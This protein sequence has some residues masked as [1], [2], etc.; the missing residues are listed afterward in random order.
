VTLAV[1]GLDILCHEGE[2]FAA[3]LAEAGVAV[4]LRRYEDMIH[5]FLSVAEAAP[6]AA[7]AIAEISTD[8]AESLAGATKEPQ[9][10]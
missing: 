6:T 3:R 1:A 9:R 8:L 4:R 10:A 7:R 2:T 5:G